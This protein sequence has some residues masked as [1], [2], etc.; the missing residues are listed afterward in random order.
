MPPDPQ[1][2]SHT[3]K[4]IG[5]AA[6]PDADMRLINTSTIT[7]EEFPS[8]HVP[9]YAILSHVW[10]A[11]EV[12]FQDMR[13]GKARKLAGYSKIA[14]CC[15][16]ADLAGWRYVWVDTC[17]IDKSSSA[18]LSEAINSM[19]RWYSH[20]Q[21]CY[22][23]LADV[24]ANF[25]KES[26]DIRQSKWFTR[27]WTL[28]ELLAPSDLIFFDRNWL[29]IGKKGEDWIN[30]QIKECTG[31]D[32][33]YWK[34]ECVAAKMSWASKR[35]TTRVEDIAYCLMGLFGVNMPTLY[36]EGQNA[37]IRLLLEILGKSNDESI[38]AWAI[39]EEGWRQGGGSAG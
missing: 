31:I 23:F 30:K 20:A 15:T 21:V 34:Q 4:S 3:Q 9:K 26:L 18:E 39:V 7:L 19:F 12:T 35:Q 1:E 24:L 5:S 33:K 14:G 29:M 13:D 17:C 32:I 16:Q 27:G 22:V 10:G 37:F 36:G 25:P 8:D 6:A 11:E 28:Q 38:F 2:S